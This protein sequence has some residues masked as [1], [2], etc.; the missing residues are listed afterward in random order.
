MKYERCEIGPTSRPRQRILHFGKQ[1]L[2]RSASSWLILVSCLVLFLLF[3]ALFIGVAAA[4]GAA[5]EAPAG[6]DNLTNGFVSQ[7]GL[8][9]CPRSL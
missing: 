7:S 3:I 1:F 6:F 4:G 8:R 2:T 5:G 9:L